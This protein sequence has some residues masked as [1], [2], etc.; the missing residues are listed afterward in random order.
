VEVEQDQVGIVLAVSSSPRPPCIAGITARRPLRQD[1][2]NEFQVGE[3]VL[4][5]EDRV[6]APDERTGTA[7]AT[8]FPCPGASLG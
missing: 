7:T 8:T 1:L 5:I 2:L 3:V 6:T 4:D